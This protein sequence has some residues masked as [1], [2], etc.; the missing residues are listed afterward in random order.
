MTSTESALANWARWSAR[1]SER[2]PVE[3]RTLAGSAEGRCY[4]PYRNSDASEAEKRDDYLD[5]VEADEPAALKCEHLLTSFAPSY[6]VVLQVHYL[7]LPC[8]LREDQF[9]TREQWQQARARTLALKLGFP[10]TV[11]Q[12]EQMLATAHEKLG[13]L[14]R[15]TAACTRAQ[16]SA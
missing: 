9:R 10:V 6:R 3:W 11:A 16:A 12:Y 2:Y 5:E 15:G 7:D 1:E 4:L 8:W 14:L 13:M